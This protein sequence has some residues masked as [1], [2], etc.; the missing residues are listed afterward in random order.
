MHLSMRELQEPHRE[1]QS[2]LLVAHSPVPRETEVVA[3]V[4]IVIH[5]EWEKWFLDTC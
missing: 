1:G 4:L 3:K 2:F 5:E